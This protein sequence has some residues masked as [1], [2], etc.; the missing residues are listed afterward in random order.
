[1]SKSVCAGCST[2]LYLGGDIH[3][4]FWILYVTNQL[5]SCHSNVLILIFDNTTNLYHLGLLQSQNKLMLNKPAIHTIGVNFAIFSLNGASI[6]LAVSAEENSL[7]LLVHEENKQ[8]FVYIRTHSQK[9]SGTTK[10]LPGL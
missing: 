4:E 3:N 5:I 10:T 1:M 9:N 7:E 6:M 2:Q 8:T